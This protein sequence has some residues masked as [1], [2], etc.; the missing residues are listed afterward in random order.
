VSHYVEAF[1]IVHS[2]PEAAAMFRA[3]YEGSTVAGK[4][5][6]LSGLYFAN[7]ALFAE[8]VEHL[9][10]LRGRESVCTMRGCFRTEERVAGVLRSKSK[11]RIRIARG[12]TLKEW[13]VAAVRLR[14]RSGEGDIAGGYTPLSLVEHDPKAPRDPL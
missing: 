10:K 12:Q 6:A 8:E 14:N 9:R 13:F 11:Y 7:P 5:Y 1:R 2:Q 3:L 4:L